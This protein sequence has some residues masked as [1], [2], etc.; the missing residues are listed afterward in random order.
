MVARRASVSSRVLAV[1]SSDS[2]RTSAPNPAAAAVPWSRAVC[3]ARGTGAVVS[4]ARAVARSVTVPSGSARRTAA[5]NRAASRPGPATSIRSGPGGWDPSARHGST[6]TPFPVG[7]GAAGR[8]P[9]RPA[10]WIVT[11]PVP[12]R[13]AGRRRADELGGSVWRRRGGPSRSRPASS[14]AAR[15]RLARPAGIAVPAP[16]RPRRERGRVGEQHGQHGPG[17]QL[18]A[19]GH[20]RRGGDHARHRGDLA[21]QRRG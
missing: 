6:T 13:E 5:F 11:V 1:S 10:T 7:S 8:A 20:R 12:D 3:A 2:S 14:P 18:P 21:L 4:A 17:G 15:S 9:T 16:G 19:L